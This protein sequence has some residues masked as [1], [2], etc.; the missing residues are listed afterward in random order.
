MSISP[1]V[2]I[3]PSLLSA[4]FSNL[5]QAAQAAEAG[6]AEYLHFDVMDGTFVPNI[7]FG[8]PVIKALRP[9][10]KRFFDVH[11]MIVQPEK[12]ITPFAEAGADGITVHAEA[13]PHLDKTLSAI[14]AHGI[15]AGVALNP[16]TAPDFL[17]YVL[18][19]IDLVLVMTV[20]P[21]F[22]GQ[23]FLPSMISK[24]ERVRSLIER[25]DHPIHIEVDGGIDTLTAPRV[26]S[27]GAT[28]LVA[29]TS[30]YGYP[31]GVA[32]GIRVLRESLS[33]GR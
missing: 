13:S 24:I 30:V 22:G 6:G 12:Y 8:M 1:D 31:S 27:A 20:N 25:T 10:S 19:K 32:E 23:T 29:G 17:E 5:Q 3:A 18:D 26:V 28:A 15:K 4:D 2:V 9:Y 7:T 33:A 14:R 11:L 21:G 16:G